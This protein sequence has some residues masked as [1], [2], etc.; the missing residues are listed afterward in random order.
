MVAGLGNWILH[1]RSDQDEKAVVLRGVAYVP[2]LGHYSLKVVA[3]K[4]REKISGKNGVTVELKSECMIHALSRGRLN[5]VVAFRTDPTPRTLPGFEPSSDK[6]A[7]DV[8]HNAFGH[9]NKFLLRETA[10]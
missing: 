8:F 6:F 2:P 1:F 10:T 3:D 7:E 9:T 4:G 5:F